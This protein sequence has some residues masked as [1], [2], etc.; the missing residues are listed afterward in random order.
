MVLVQ[1]FEVLLSKQMDKLVY[2]VSYIAS[3]RLVY[4]VE[5]GA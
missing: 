1:N 5:R 2:T 4:G 3:D